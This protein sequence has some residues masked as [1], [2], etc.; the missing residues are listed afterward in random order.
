MPT[1]FNASNTP[2]SGPGPLTVN[3]TSSVTKSPP[4]TNVW[5]SSSWNFGDGNT[6]TLQNP[7]HTY[8]SAG[9]FTPSVTI[10]ANA[11]GGGGSTTFTAP[12]DLTYIT[13]TIVGAAFTFSPSSPGVN[14]TVTF[15]DTSSGATTWLWNFGDGTTSTLQNPTH[16]YT[17]VNTYTVQLTINGGVSS[18]SHPITV[19]AVPGFTYNP[20]TGYT[21]LTVAFTDTSVGATSWYWQFGDGTTSTLQNPTHTYTSAGS[22]TASLTVNGSGT[23]VSHVISV[24]ASSASFAVYPTTFDLN[25]PVAFMDTSTGSSQWLW[26]FGDGGTSTLQ[27]PV[28]TFT[29]GSSAT[30]TLTINN[31]GST[32]T[33]TI[34]VVGVLPP[35]SNFTLNTNNIFANSMVTFTDLSTDGPVSWRWNF[36]DGTQYDTNQN[37]SHIYTIPGE[38]IVS[39]TTSNGFGS[40]VYYYGVQTEHMNDPP[41]ILDADDGITVNQYVPEGVDPQVTLY[42]SND[43]GLTWGNPLKATLGRLGNYRARARFNRLGYARDRVFKI[44]ITEAVQVQMLMAM[45]DFEVGDS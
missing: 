19:S 32:S 23:P 6:S 44:V 36:G 7:T 8:T 41:G 5:A 38:Y 9:T 31:G 28:H 40:S 34:N 43:G 27:N 24:S 13:V 20:S 37:T 11:T 26:N 18:V 22:F 14:Q 25:W 21:N 10:T 1:I 33:Q 2:S 29:S 30:V 15:T 45:M 35:L 17:A 16:T 12:T 42:I 4:G 39:L 3:F